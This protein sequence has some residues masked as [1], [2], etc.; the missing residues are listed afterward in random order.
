MA[1]AARPR[2]ASVLPPPVGKKSRS[3]ISRCGSLGSA[4]PRQVQQEEGEL[5]RPPFGIVD[6]G[7]TTPER[8]ADGTV[9]DPERVQR[10]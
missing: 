9:C 1:K 2:Y 6:V 4:M 5:E 10:I 7:E 3:T 8:G